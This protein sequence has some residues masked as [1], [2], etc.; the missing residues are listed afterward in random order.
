MVGPPRTLRLLR[1]APAILRLAQ[2]G[3]AGCGYG[4]R[5]LSRTVNR[6]A[7]A[8]AD[9]FSDFCFHRE[10]VLAIA[11]GHERSAERM[12]VNRALDLDQAA[13]SEKL[14]RLRPD[15]V[16]PSPGARTFS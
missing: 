13:G 14:H 16:D 12:T 11:H 15:K 1:L 6:V 9:D 4:I 3:L 10:H 2:A 5:S 8:L 7:H